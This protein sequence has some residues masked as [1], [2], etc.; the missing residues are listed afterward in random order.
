MKRKLPLVIALGVA[1]WLVINGALS[2]AADSTNSHGLSFGAKAP[3]F[4]LKDKD[5]KDHA[6]AD[7][8]KKAKF[9]ALVFYRSADW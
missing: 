1:G 6:L 4:T 3:S 5:G 9:V 7:S 2:R 8:Q